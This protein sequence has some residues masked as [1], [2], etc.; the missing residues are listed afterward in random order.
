[1]GSVRPHPVEHVDDLCV[2]HSMHTDLPE[3]AVAILMMNLG[4][5]QPNRPSLGAWLG[6][7]LGAENDNL[8]GLIP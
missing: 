7:G 8:P 5:L 2:I 6:Y 4:S 1:M 3:H